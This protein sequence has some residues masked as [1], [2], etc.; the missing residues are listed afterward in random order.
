ML[1][2]YKDSN[3]TTATIQVDYIL[4]FATETLLV[5]KI[6]NEELLATVGEDDQLVETL[7]A[8][9]VFYDKND[10]NKFYCECF[11]RDLTNII[12]EEDY[13]V[14]NPTKEMNYYLANPDNIGNLCIVLRNKDNKLEPPKVLSPDESPNSESECCTLQFDD[15]RSALLTD[16][17]DRVEKI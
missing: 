12:K 9:S 5:G 17:S 13:T 4:K 14:S 16:I 6:N 2:T 8:L 1:V 15:E 10:K 11:P 7:L 3:N